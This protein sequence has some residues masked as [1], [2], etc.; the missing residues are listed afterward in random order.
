MTAALVRRREAN[1]RRGRQLLREGKVS[2]A[3]DCF[4]RCVNITPA[5]AHNLI[6]VW[7]SEFSQAWRRR[8]GLQH[9]RSRLSQGFHDGTSRTAYRL[10]LCRCQLHSTRSQMNQRCVCVNS[11]SCLSIRLPGPEGWTAS[12][13][14]TKPMLSW[15]T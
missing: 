14:R 1:L 5:M 9:R 11:S 15:L 3:R 8:S 7:T 4:T 10:P 2:E 12:W 13:L 6:K